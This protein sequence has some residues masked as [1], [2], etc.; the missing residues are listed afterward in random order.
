MNKQIDKK[1]NSNDANQVASSLT[2]ISVQDL[3]LVVEHNAEVS[4]AVWVRALMQNWRQGTV[5]CKSRGEISFSNKKPWKQKGTGR[6]RA[7]SAR[8]PLW[9]SGGVIFGPQPRV[10]SLKINK[11]NKSQVLSAC[12]AS[13]ANRGNL[14]AFDW[15]LP[16]E[17]PSTALAHKAFSNAG[18]MDKKVTLFLPR[19]DFTHWASMNNLNYVQVLSFDDVN[20]YELSLGNC[21]VVLQ[22]DIG[23]FKDMVA[24]WN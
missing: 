12:M 20:A 9:R 22:K 19:E 2:K 6:A 1:M 15:T 3:G 16:G 7:G 21:I 13:Y 23:M 11:K 14:F 24:K 10:R 4:Y 17:K 8:S 5:G 18:L